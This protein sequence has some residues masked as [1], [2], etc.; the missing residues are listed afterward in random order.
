LQVEPIHFRVRLLFVR[1]RL[2]CQSLAD[3]EVQTVKYHELIP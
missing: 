2:G 3:R 1:R